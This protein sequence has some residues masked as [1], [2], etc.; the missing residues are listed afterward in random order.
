MK[1][2]LV[3]TAACIPL[4]AGL[5][6]P[7]VA[8]ET[9]ATESRVSNETIVADLERRIEG[10]E[11]KVGGETVNSAFQPRGP[12]VRHLKVPAQASSWN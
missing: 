7:S 3:V 2:I 8:D 10:L 4:Y 12:K 11:A 1:T 6:S 5:P 9:Q